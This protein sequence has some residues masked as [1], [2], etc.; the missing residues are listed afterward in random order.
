[1]IW[2]S[3]SWGRRCGGIRP[4]RSRE[5]LT[6]C[7]SVATSTSINDRLGAM[8]T[9]VAGISWLNAI[10]RLLSSAQ[11]LA[12]AAADAAPPHGPGVTATS[13]FHAVVR[14]RTV[15]GGA[16]WRR[17]RRPCRSRSRSRR[18]TGVHDQLGLG[19]QGDRGVEP[20]PPQG[21]MQPGYFSEIVRDCAS[22]YLAQLSPGPMFHA[23][24]RPCRRGGLDVG[25]LVDDDVHRLGRK[26]R[27]E[28]APK[29]VPRR[30]R[31]GDGGL[32]RL[33]GDRAARLRASLSSRF[34]SNPTGA[35][36][37]RRGSSSALEQAGSSNVVAFAAARRRGTSEVPMK[38]LYAPLERVFRSVG[39]CACRLACWPRHD[40]RLSRPALS[41][42]HT[43]RRA[44]LPRRPRRPSASAPNEPW[45]DAFSPP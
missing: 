4:R 43:D 8:V 13:M 21:L 3:T 14:A 2:L 29:A 18:G 15:A 38:V 27:R 45:T 39:G 36:S 5:P 31:G 6:S 16:T 35:A 22:L 1:M 34:T 42:G 7:H 11:K 12:R 32:V 37:C 28:L 26:Q 25:H 17:T 30:G 10:E 44:M 33:V 9:P 24:R 19:H 20:V 40:R 41:R 23:P